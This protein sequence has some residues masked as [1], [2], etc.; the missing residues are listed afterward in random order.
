MSLYGVAAG[1]DTDSD[2][3]ASLAEYAL[4]TDPLNARSSRREDLLP[5][6]GRD[7]DGSI[8]FTFALPSSNGSTGR[9]DVLVTVES[10]ANPATGPWT[11]IASKAGTA[12]WS[13]N[14]V[15]TGT[16]EGGSVPVSVRI[17]PPPA[18]NLFI[19]LKFA[20]M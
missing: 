11:A 14:A 7:P 8:R 2:G 10:A 6:S 13:S 4:G 5:R 18:G 9:P 20:G 1:A 3:L 19:R 12:A 15:T 16:P 17:V